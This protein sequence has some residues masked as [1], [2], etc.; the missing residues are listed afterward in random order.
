[1]AEVE[2]ELWKRVCWVFVVLRQH[3]SSSPL[4]LTS[5]RPSRCDTIDDMTVVFVDAVVVEG[6]KRSLGL[7]SR[8]GF[9]VRVT[10]FLCIYTWRYTFF[11]SQFTTHSTAIVTAGAR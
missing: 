7:P 3:A 8:G 4:V 10:I 11:T 1:M 2:L 5:E 6:Q 9:P